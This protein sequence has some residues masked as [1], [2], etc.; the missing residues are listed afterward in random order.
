[1]NI[2]DENI[3]KY[4]LNY[5]NTEEPVIKEMEEYGNKKGFPIVGPSVG[6][7]LQQYCMLSKAKRVLELGSG[8]GYSAAW[9]F[10]GMLTNGTVTCT[11]YSKENVELGRDYMTRLG[12][13]GV[14]NFLEGDA[15][16]LI[17]EQEGRFDIIF[18]DIDK[19]Q[20]PK[21]FELGLPLLRKGGLFI[22]DN[23]LWKG[24]VAEEKPDAATQGVLEYN[25]KIFNTPGVL[26][27]II[28]LRD[29]VSV[30]IKI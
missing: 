29:G 18:N 21:A 24:K 22:T 7:L 14:V 17:N 25:R 15:L 1:M 30:S 6:R 16:E 10:M 8:F 12:A 23:V 3:E 20:Y 13:V 26:S 27:T 11:E 2:V 4:L 9:F 19:E 5:A 28:P